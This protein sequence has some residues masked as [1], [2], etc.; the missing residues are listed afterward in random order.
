MDWLFQFRKD[1]TEWNKILKL[2]EK[3][4]TF[5]R[6]NGLFRGCDQELRELLRLSPKA[7]ERTFKIRWSLIEYV[8]DAS[9]KAKPGECL[10]GSSEV[11]E[12]VFG[13]FKY[14]QAE[15]T[16]GSLTGMVLAIP[17][18]VSKTTEAVVQRALETVPVH[19][20]RTWIKEKFGKSNLTKRREA[21][22]AP[23]NAEQNRINYPSLLEGEFI[24][25][26]L[27]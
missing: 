8:L 14:M 11:I 3:T 18:M 22:S 17:A 27:G 23:A 19:K 21:F 10:L 15:H 5:V 13:K 1:L 6:T 7:T 24:T 12:S 25:P 26:V 2:V 20:V 16:E 4:E 9:L